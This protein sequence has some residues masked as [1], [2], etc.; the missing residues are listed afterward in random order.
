MLRFLLLLLS[1]CSTI[2]FAQIRFTNKTDDFLINR[3]YSPAT[4]IQEDP[5]LFPMGDKGFSVLWKDYREGEPKNYV[6]FFNFNGEPVDTNFASDYSNF[7]Y[8]DSGCTL[9]IRSQTY[10]D[11]VLGEGL[12]AVYGNIVKPDNSSCGEKALAFV[13]LP[14]CGTGWMGI[15]ED[16]KPASNGFLYFLNAGGSV[17]VKR[18]DENCNLVYDSFSEEPKSYLAANISGAVTSD[19]DYALFYYQSS[20][21]K[22]ADGCGVYG[23]FYDSNNNVL[24]DTVKIFDFNYGFLIFDEAP[25]VYAAAL[26]NDQYLVL[27]IDQMAKKIY[28]QTFLKNGFPASQPT[29][30]SLEGTLH[31]AEYSRITSFF[32]SPISEDGFQIFFSIADGNYDSEKTESYI[33]KFNGDGSLFG[34]IYKSDYV[35]PDIGKSVVNKSGNI[36]YAPFSDGKDVF[37]SDLNDFDFIN[38]RLINDDTFGGNQSHPAVSIRN[39]GTFFA[40]WQDEESFYGRTINENGNLI[41]D[42]YELYN[43]HAKFFKNGGAIAACKRFCGSEWKAGY[44]ILD[45]NMV[46]IRTELI[47]RN[48]DGY[49]LVI[50]GEVISDDLALVEY[51]NNDSLFV[52]LVN[53]AGDIL[54]EKFLTEISFPDGLKIY[55]ENDNVFWIA[56]HNG[57]KKIDADLNILDE[58]NGNFTSYLGDDKFLFAYYDDDLEELRFSILDKDHNIVVENVS[59]AEQVSNWRAERLTKDI[60]LFTYFRNNSLY[61]KAFTNKGEIAGSETLVSSDNTSNKKEAAFGVSGDKILFTWVDDRLG[62]AGYDIFGAVFNFE[63]IISDA[64]DETTIAKFELKQNYP[65]PFNPST[66][67]EYVIPQSLAGKKVALKVFNSL[68]KEVAVLVNETENYGKHKITFDGSFLAS[69]VYYFSLRAG[70]KQITK[71]GVLLK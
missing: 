9:E 30:V 2:T 46:S 43:T 47:A 7:C 27:T 10:Y 64:V 57:A 71:K 40:M 31:T 59:A 5:E 13:N 53:G 61:A 37:L 16:F 23:I 28:Y 67:I 17:G 41:G 56:W 25:K 32:S 68:G 29:S 49:K 35:F 33:V 52:L 4:F 50:T 55:K 65:N 58:F 12:Y 21:K 70:D 22:Y 11:E 44:R 60:F 1:L 45:S 34:Q 3:E 19:D 36:F 62:V 42:E 14:W 63:D 24:A 39:D 54:N 66:T 69:G 8:S 51:A 48:D 26:S 6:Q 38:N 15:H 20:E 18:I